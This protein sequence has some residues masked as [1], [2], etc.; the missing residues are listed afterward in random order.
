VPAGGWR[1][2]GIDV[3]AY[4]SDATGLTT[5]FASGNLKIWDDRPDAP[6]ASMVWGNPNFNVLDTVVSTNTY[7]IF[8]TASFAGGAPAQLPDATRLIWRASLVVP[9]V[10]LPAGTYWLDFQLVPATPTSDVFIPPVT[11]SSGA[12]ARAMVTTPGLQ[13]RIGPLGSAAWVELSDAGRPSASADVALDVPYVVIGVRKCGPADVSGG[14]GGIGDYDGLLT[15]QDIFDFLV[16]WFSSDPRADV[17][18]TNGVNIT[19]IFDFLTAWF[20]GC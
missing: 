12:G 3:F 8:S 6:G 4:Q 10:E 11:R 20:A 19:D 17:N 15:V 16:L 7:R 13:Y 14:P 18:G 2:Q 1:V 5:P 9:S